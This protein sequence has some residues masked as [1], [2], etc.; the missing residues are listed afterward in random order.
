[1]GKELEDIYNEKNFVI[2]NEMMRY[3]GGR[4]YYYKLAR[5]FASIMYPDKTKDEIIK[6]FPILTIDMSRIILK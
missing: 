1:M 6:M 2:Q 4:N 5:E 3:I